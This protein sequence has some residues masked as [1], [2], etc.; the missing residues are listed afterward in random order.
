MKQNLVIIGTGSTAKVVYSFVEF[1]GLYNVLGFAVNR[2][3]LNSSTYCDKPVYAIEDLERIM[4]KNNDLLF[5]AI[6][7]NRLNADRRFVYENLKAKGYLFANVVSPNAI[8]KGQL[9]GDN[10]W[11]ADLVS[12]ESGSTIGANC[13]M[14]AHAH[15]E[16][17][18]SIGDH[19]FIGA[20]A[21][22]A[23]GCKIGEQSFIGLSATVFDDT[24]IGKKCIIGAS[25]AVKRNMPDFSSCKT[26]SCAYEIKQ[27]TEAEIESKLMFSK[28]VRELTLVN[29]G[30]GEPPIT[31]SYRRAA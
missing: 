17:N 7:W 21:L 27:Y 12:I 31:I 20:N 2:A 25:T 5:V 22:I 9:L 26:A 18:T 3:Y 19:C 11:I 10:C 13:F 6:Q 23:G 30:G 16:D 24:T 14:R 29:R 4:D 28:N 15:I 1:Y 8:I